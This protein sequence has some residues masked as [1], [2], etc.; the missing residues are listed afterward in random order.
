MRT[1]SGAAA[2]VGATQGAHQ[3]QRGRAL[4]SVLDEQVEEFFLIVFDALVTSEQAVL[5]MVVE[6]FDLEAYS[7]KMDFHHHCVVA[8]RFHPEP[9]LVVSQKFQ[10]RKQILDPAERHA[11]LLFPILIST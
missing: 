1:R 3:R 8:Q 5:D 2:K 7:D 4:R 6:E 10:E 11:R 9:D